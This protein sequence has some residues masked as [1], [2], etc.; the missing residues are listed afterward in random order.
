MKL[1]ALILAVAA[2]TPA[3]AADREHVGKFKRDWLFDYMTNERCL[4]PDFKGFPSFKLCPPFG[5]DVAHDTHGWHAEVWNPHDGR[6]RLAM[7]AASSD[8]YNLSVDVW[9]FPSDSTDG[10]PTPLERRY[11]LWFYARGDSPSR[12]NGARFQ[13]NLGYDWLLARDVKRVLDALYDVLGIRDG[14]AVG[15]D[16]GGRGKLRTGL[17]IADFRLETPRMAPPWYV[18]ATTITGTPSFRLASGCN[19]VPM[20]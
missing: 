1:L 12:S 9:V 2:T 20:R 17:V 18:S 7:T 11:K 14:A 3:L 13:V 16:C 19:L 5:E 15:L 8:G 6:Q 10:R 4:W